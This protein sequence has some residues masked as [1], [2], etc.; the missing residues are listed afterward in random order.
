ML[1]LPNNIDILG[2][3]ETF[4][5]QTVD[6]DILSI[7]GYTLERKDRGQCNLLKAE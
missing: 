2:V 4:L 3:C 7:N 1:D 5:D 6:N